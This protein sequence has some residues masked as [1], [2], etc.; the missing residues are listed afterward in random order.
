M[1]TTFMESTK[2][3][4]NGVPFDPGSTPTAVVRTVTFAEHESATVVFDVSLPPH[5]PYEESRPLLTAKVTVG[6]LAADGPI[7]QNAI[8]KAANQ[9]TDALEKVVH[10]IGHAQ[11]SP[12]PPDDGIR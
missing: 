11:L 8:G 12:P 2:L 3:E 10:C 6:G 7:V 5:S 9:V 1:Y 4:I